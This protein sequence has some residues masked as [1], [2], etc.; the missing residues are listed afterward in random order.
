MRARIPIDKRTKKQSSKR[1]RQKYKNGNLRQHSAFFKLFCYVLHND[2]GFLR[3]CYDVIGK[4][5][6]LIKEQDEDPIFCEHLDRAVINQLGLPFSREKTDLD[7]N[8]ID[9]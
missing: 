7:G 2:Y 5:S 6:E 8:L 1:L 3:R 4:V 9:E